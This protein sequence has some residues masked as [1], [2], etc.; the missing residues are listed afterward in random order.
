[1]MVLVLC[2]QVAYLPFLQLRCIYVEFILIREK[3][4]LV[5][6]LGS[7]PTVSWCNDLDCCP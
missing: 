4:Q 6:V 5:K 7:I 3:V 2:L 1:M